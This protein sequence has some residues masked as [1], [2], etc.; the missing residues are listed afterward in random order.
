MAI[1][2]LAAV[3]GRARFDVRVYAQARMLGQV[4]CQNDFLAGSDAKADVRLGD[5]KG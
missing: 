2:G 4:S 3:Y 5:S 1:R